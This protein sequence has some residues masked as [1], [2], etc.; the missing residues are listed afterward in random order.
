M[1]EITDV[2]EP[3]LET[4]YKEHELNGTTFQINDGRICAVVR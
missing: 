4:L 2:K 1:I 3:T